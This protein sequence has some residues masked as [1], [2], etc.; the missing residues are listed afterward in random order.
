MSIE[1][2]FINKYYPKNIDSFELDHDLKDILKLL[3]KI[4]TINI[5]FIGNSCTGKT[6]LIKTIVNLYFDNN[7][8]D[9]NE[10]T[11]NITCLKDQGI[12]F[13]RNEV[14]VFCQTKCLIK[15]KKKN[16]YIG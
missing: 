7:M 12:N 13:Y 1:K 14:K 4:D 9:I 8:K 16:S 5:L 3:L 15:N 11:L 2:L 10:N 6:T